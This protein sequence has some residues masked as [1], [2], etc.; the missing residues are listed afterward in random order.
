MIEID[1]DKK[2]NTKLNDLHNFQITLTLTIDKKNN[3][4]LNDLHN[5]QITNNPRFD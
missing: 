3:T 4:K 1:I 5:F 2:N